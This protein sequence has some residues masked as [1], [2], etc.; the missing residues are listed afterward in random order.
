MDKITQEIAAAVKRAI[1]SAETSEHKV[2]Q[3]IGL[4]RT[5]F[6]RRAEGHSSFTGTDLVKIAKHLGTDVRDFFSSQQQS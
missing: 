4:P 2:A 3:A 6:Y 1:Q 5:T